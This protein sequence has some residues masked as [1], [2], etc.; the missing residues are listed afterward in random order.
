MPKPTWL[1][2]AALAVSLLPFV[3]LVV[4][5]VAMQLTIVGHAQ[6]A[7]LQTL[8]MALMVCQ[9]GMVVTW[10]A[11]LALSIAAN[12]GVA[13]LAPAP[14]RV[15]RASLGVTIGFAMLCGLGL[16]FSVFFAIYQRSH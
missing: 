2:T 13:A 16:I 9:C 7:A 10:V 8:G 1:P 14:R 5:V 3:L 15:A 4:E 11:G 12:R 6:R